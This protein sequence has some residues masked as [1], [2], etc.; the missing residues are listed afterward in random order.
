MRC[1][2]GAGSSIIDPGVAAG[3]GQR[4]AFDAGRHGSRG[5]R[6]RPCRGLRPSIVRCDPCS[7]LSDG[8]CVVDPL[9]RRGSG[10][11]PRGFGRRRLMVV[12]PLDAGGRRSQPLPR[13]NDRRTSVRGQWP[14]AG[15]CS[16]LA[17]PYAAAAVADAGSASSS[18]DPRAAVVSLPR[19]RLRSD[20]KATSPTSTQHGNDGE[21]PP[22]SPREATCCRWY[23]TPA[24][25]SAP[26]GCSCPGTCEAGQLGGEIRPARC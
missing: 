22:P 11:P 6:Y 3:V 24:G 19:R 25:C 14:S 23:P 7:H 26:C 20:A 18:S 9:R 17:A 16:V 13:R 10:D 12:G 4:I 5:R 21:Q 15:S 1:A 2:F 8:A